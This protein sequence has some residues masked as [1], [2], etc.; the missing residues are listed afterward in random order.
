MPNPGA[1]IP[2]RDMPRSFAQIS[3]EDA[4]STIGDLGIVDNWNQ[5]TAFDTNGPSFRST[6]DQA[7][8]KIVVGLT[9]MYRIAFSVCFSGSSGELM[10]VSAQKNTGSVEFS[11]VHAHRKLGGGDLGSMSGVGFVS[12]TKDDEI[13]LWVACTSA[14]NKTVTIE[15]ISLIIERVN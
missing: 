11:N 12:L 13:E 7:N 15:D 9:G 8:N 10:K 1:M 4:G 14:A 5:I 6:A 3:A 2:Y